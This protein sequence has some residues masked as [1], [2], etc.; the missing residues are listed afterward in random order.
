MIAGYVERHHQRPHSGL[1]YQSPG[2]VATT[3]R[4]HHELPALAAKVTTCGVHVSSATGAPSG[5]TETNT[6]ER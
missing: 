4:D 3:K 5:T 2:Q 1:T 6:I